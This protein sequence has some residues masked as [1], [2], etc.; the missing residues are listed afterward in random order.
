VNRRC[1]RCHPSRY[2]CAWV[3][4]AVAVSVLSF[5]GMGRASADSSAAT[6]LS[7]CLASSA[8]LDVLFVIDESGSLRE[9]DPAN[10]RVDA[11]R[12]ALSALEQLQ[13]SSTERIG[14]PLAVTVAFSGFA[15]EFVQRTPWIPVKANSQTF[16]GEAV[17][18]FASRNRGTYTNYLAALDGAR[19]AFAQRSATTNDRDGRSVCKALVFVTDGRYDVGTR[20]AMEAGLARLCEA[21]GIIDGLRTD[22]VH[23]FVTGLSV[24][25]VPIA[26]PDLNVLRAI[27]GESSGVRCGTA[28]LPPG[29]AQGSFLGVND[30]GSLIE[31]LFDSVNQV[32]GGTRIPPTSVSVCDRQSCPTGTVSFVVDRGLRAFNLLAQTGAVGVEIELG[33]P[34]GER[35][36][37]PNNAGGSAR[38]G[39]ASLGWSWIA[40]DVATVKGI[41]PA[42]SDDWI[43]RW[44]VTFVDPSGV[45]LGAVARAQVYVFGDLE[46]KLVRPRTVRRGEM[47]EVAVRLVRQR[48]TPRAPGPFRSVRVQASVVDPLTDEGASVE[49]RQGAD[50]IYR[51]SV[52]VPQSVA[53]SLVNVSV[54]AQPVTTSGLALAPVIRTTAMPVSNPATFPTVKPANLRL[55]RVEGS[56]VARGALSVRG[57]TRPGCVWIEAARFGQRPPAVTSVTVRSKP[58]APTAERCVRIPAGAPRNIEILATPSGVGDGTARGYVRL[59]LRAETEP[60]GITLDVP[61]TFEMLR[62]VRETRR[63]AI[64]AGLL[65]AGIAPPFII[66]MLINRSL[67]RFTPAHELR[68]ALVVVEAVDGR[69]RR[70]DASTRELLQPDDFENMPTGTGRRSFVD[71]DSGIHFRSR[72]RWLSASWGEAH[73][74]GARL[75]TGQ[76]PR[77]ADDRV[78]VP[79]SLGETWIL[80]MPMGMSTSPTADPSTDGDLSV[81]E[82]GGRANLRLLAFCDQHRDVVDQIERMIAKIHEVTEQ[83]MQSL[84]PADQRIRSPLGSQEGE[85]SPVPP[86]PPSILDD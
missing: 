44:T 84:A 46:P 83:L 85:A 33:S 58:S 1:R 17:G 77:F 47:V 34:A 59:Q 38:L 50:G 24:E 32:G 57:G 52:V 68:R 54:Q 81:G 79:L 2:G 82:P 40:P 14:K 31:G 71:S 25:S 49:L 45:N 36:R 16:L 5:A 11:V 64:V 69:F 19:V 30:V 18:A 76:H 55:S 15:S 86:R 65:A 72:S 80:L 75:A 60:R 8:R 37:I 26:E 22:G 27:A 4:V 56:G 43:G 21:G 3:V 20:A 35:L 66:L 23:L 67:A 53:T 7:D 41:L 39:S 62:P 12:A 78:R 42:K 13:R 74:P 29:A 70:G 10:R 63:F 73:A 9:T 61:V 28:P 6:Q 51:G 48:G